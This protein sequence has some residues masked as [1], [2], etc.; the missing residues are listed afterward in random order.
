MLFSGLGLFKPRN[1]PKFTD[2][3]FLSW[4]LGYR[5]SIDEGMLPEVDTVSSG[6]IKAM[7]DP[8]S[9]KVAVT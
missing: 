9:A 4:P 8:C 6:K 5:E 2:F 1:I 3:R 7:G